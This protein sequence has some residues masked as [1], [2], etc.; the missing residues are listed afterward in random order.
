MSKTLTLDEIFYPVYNYGWPGTGMPNT[1][2]QMS[3]D[4]LKQ[5]ILQ[6]V[7]DEVV[8]ENEPLN[9]IDSENHRTT[10]TRGY[11]SLRNEQRQTLKDHGW[12]EES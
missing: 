4:E 2:K 8:G 12:K 6:W 9:I 5:A 11:N 3:P 1:Q 10:F 7:A